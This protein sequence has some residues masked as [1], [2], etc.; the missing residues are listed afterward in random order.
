MMQRD[1]QQKKGLYITVEG[2]DGS[3]KS[4]L[5]KRLAEYLKPCVATDIIVT[6]EPGGTELG[7]T[8]RTL[9]QSHKS[10]ICDRAEFLLFAA[11]RAQHIQSIVL[12]ALGKGSIVISDR[13]F[14][15][16]I[17]YQGFGRG[18]DCD[19]LMNINEWAI[20][21]VR[22]DVI[23]YL[24]LDP[25][26]ARQRIEVR[27]EIKTSFEQEQLDFWKRVIKGF[28]YCCTRYPN[29]KSLDAFR[30]QNE[31]FNN[32]LDAVKKQIVPFLKVD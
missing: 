14:I 30:P 12:P 26:I 31:V 32:A 1:L 7:K 15:S 28:E 25:S 22:P 10:I 23:L 24:Q 5:I 29:M 9:V 27:N 16:S 13:S 3:G 8:L 20:N 4:E 2:I 6:K 21:G 11:D 18:L 19:T 17:A